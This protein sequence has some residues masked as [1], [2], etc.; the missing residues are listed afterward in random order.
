MMSGGLCAGVF[1]SL[2]CHHSTIFRGAFDG[3]SYTNEILSAGM[4]ATKKWKTT[5]RVERPGERS[6]SLGAHLEVM[7]IG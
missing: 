1:W 2:I 5:L 4:S 3:V 7:G 6:I